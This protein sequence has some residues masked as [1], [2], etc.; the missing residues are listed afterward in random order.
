MDWD[1][2]KSTLQGFGFPPA[3]VSLI[4]HGITSTTISLLW[5]GSKTP[6]FSPRRRLRQGEPLSPYLFVLCMERLGA[7]ITEEVNRGQWIPIQVS[8]DGP[9]ISHLFFADDVLLFG[10][11]KPSQ[12]R[13][14]ANVLQEFCGFSGMKVNVEKSRAYA[15]K[16]VSTARRNKTQGITQINFTNLGKYLGFRMVEECPKR[17]DFVDIVDRIDSKLASWKGRLLNK[18]GRLTLANS[19]LASVP[20]YAMQIT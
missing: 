1:F 17:E 15:S 11:A 6:E 14:I 20:S 7:M 16:G 4:M 10:K 9:Q 13:L 18:P 5:N 19:V 8:T 12:T 3:I 2:L